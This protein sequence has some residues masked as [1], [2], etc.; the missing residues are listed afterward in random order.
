MFSRS[1]GC[2]I[3]PLSQS[4]TYLV[5]SCSLNKVRGQ[6]RLNKTLECHFCLSLA[7]GDQLKV[8]SH[9]KRKEK[10]ETLKHGVKYNIEIEVRSKK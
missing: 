1:I 5:N 7:A 6:S 9:E 10:E 4:N 2:V 8:S 3:F